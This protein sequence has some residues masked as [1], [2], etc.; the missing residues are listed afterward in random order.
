MPPIRPPQART[1]LLICLA[2]LVVGCAAV[3]VR[4]AD[5][6]PDLLDAWKASVLAGDQ[7]SPRTLQTLRRCDLD[8]AYRV[9]PAEAAAQLHA[10]ALKDPQPELLFALA[11]MS[12]LQG[13]RSEKWACSDAVGHYY[14]SAGYAYFYLFACAGQAPN[15]AVSECGAATLAPSDPFDPRFRLACDLYNASLAKCI[16]AAQRVGR[17]DPRHELRLP[18]GNGGGA[19]TLSV[20]HTGFLWKPEEFGPLL[21]CNDYKVEGLQNQNHAYGLGVPLIATRAEDA[22][23]PEH[24]YYPKQVSFP[25]TAFFRFDGGLAELAEHRTGQLELYNPLTIQAI[26]VRGRSVPLETDLTTPLAYYLAN[27]KLHGLEYLAF[28]RGDYLQ[29]RS[30]IHMLEPYQPGKIPVVLVHGLLSSP[31]TWAP[32][33]NELQ[34]DPEL[35]KRFQ[36]LVT[37]YPTGNPYIATAADLRRDLDKFRNDLDPEHKDAALDNMVFIGHS[38][39]GLISKLLTV[40]SGDDFWRQVDNRPFSDLTLRPETRAEL[41]RIYFFKRESCVRRV[42]F[43]G[44]PHH[45]S[46]LSPSP[47]GRLGDDLVRLPKNLVDAAK[48]VA[49]ENPGQPVIQAFQRV[50]TSVDLLAPNAPALELLASRPHPTGVHYHSVV[51]VLPPSKRTFLERLLP[52]ASEEGDGIVPYTSAHLDDAESELIVPADHFHVHQH[53]LAVLE[54]RRILMEHAKEADGA[55][56]VIP[57]KYSG[58]H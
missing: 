33:F 47:L 44:T 16:T 29:G 45:G 43:L 54:I 26:E 51:G 20:V 1:G 2:L 21:S 8:D 55:G 12:Y 24:N 37:F 50:S 13:R 9:R 4:K 52:G 42:I 32:V 23:P 19:F 11:E 39:G 5:R 10:L 25:A 7:L 46:L 34:A 15:A 3:T 18:S 53:P 49:A 6:A 41:Q 35:R 17:L 48:D 57:V 36:F 22:P 30:G 27:A 28:L 31:L 56:E 14:L 38:M 58:E 40:D